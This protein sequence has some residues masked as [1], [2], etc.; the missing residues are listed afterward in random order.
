M[1]YEN[2]KR[3]TLP[4]SYAGPEYPDYYLFLGQHRDSSCLDRSNFRSGLKIIGGETETVRVICDGHW[5]VGW[6]EY[7]LIHESDADA[8]AMADEILGAIEE[9]PVVVESDFCEL[10]REE[11]DDIW[12]YCYT[13]AERI[14]YIRK[15]RDQFEFHDYADMIGCIR[16]HYFVGYASELIG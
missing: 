10:E 9:Y 13:P 2:I 3:W 16:G 7:I 5:A 12:R 11:A 1:T 6:I 14:E 15:N 4:D 8:L